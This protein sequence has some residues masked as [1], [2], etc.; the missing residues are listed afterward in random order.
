[1]KMKVSLLFFFFLTS[2]FVNAQST[3]ELQSENQKLKQQISRLEEKVQFCEMY[4]KSSTIE[5]RSFNEN[6]DFK[7]LS[8]V[9]NSIEQ[10]VKIEVFIEQN[11]LPNQ[12]LSLWIGSK[13]PIAYDETGKGY[14]YKEGFF[15]QASDMMGTLTFSLYTGVGVR[16]TIIFRNVLP[17]TDRFKLVTGTF[18]NQ[19]ADGAGNKGEGPFEIKNLIITWNK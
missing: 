15:P 10:T 9:G 3:Q 11:S 6:F 8:C 18:E 7:V 14:E 19:N 4:E 2:L 16:G 13:K 17:Q 1:M 12:K 5:T